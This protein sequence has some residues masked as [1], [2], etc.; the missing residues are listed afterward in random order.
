MTSHLDDE[1][2][3]DIQS[4]H[5]DYFDSNPF[6]NDPINTQQQHHAPLTTSSRHSIQ[7]SNNNN[8]S[9]NNSN[10][11]H[12]LHLQHNQPHQ[13][14]QQQQ[15]MDSP[16]MMSNRNNENEYDNDN[17]D[18][19]MRPNDDDDHHDSHKSSGLTHSRGKH[20]FT[21]L[22]KVKMSKFESLDFPIIDNQ[23]MRDFQ[24]KTTIFSHML[25]TFGKWAICFTIGV[26]VGCV[27]YLVK[28]SVEFV[29]EF[30][31]STS[32]RYT[33]EGKK[34][35]AFFVYYSINLLFGVLA[36]LIIIPVGQISSGSGI[37]EVKGYLNGI[38]IPQSMNA[39]TLIGKA[40]S[41]IFAYSSGLVLGPEGPMIH[42]G[43]MVG[44]AIGQVKS[45][46]FKW[47][48]KLFWRYHNDRDRRDF[49]STGAAAGVAAAFGAPIGGVLFGYEE[50]SSFWS[51]QL[52]WRTFFACLIATFT[53]NL[54]LQ[55]FQVQVH[56]YGVLT[57][58]FSQEYL[59]RY[60]ELLAFAALGVIGGLLGAFFVYLNVRLS[61]WR[62]EFFSKLPVYTRVLEVVLVVTLTSVTLFTAAGVTG[63]REQSL[64]HNTTIIPNQN[65]TFVRLFCEEDQYNDMAGLSFNTMD[66]ALRLLYSRAVNL[67]SIPTLVVFTFISFILATIT[68]GLMLA[69]GL[70]IPM[71]LLGGTFGRLVGQLGS[72]MFSHANPPI[73]PSIYA[74]VGSSAM[75]AGFSRMTIS[76]AIIVVELT[77][78]TQ[79]MLP[80][81]LSVMIAKWVGDIFNESIY[82]HLMELKCY[83]YLPS[84]PPKSMIKL[85]ITDVMKTEVVTLFEVDK[86]SRIMDVLQSNQHAGFPVIEKHNPKTVDSGDYSEDGIYCGMILRSQLIILLNYKIFTQEQQRLPNNFK[87][88]KHQRR[89]GKA[90]DY[91][92][93][94]ADGRMTYQVMT[95][96][97]ARHFPPINQMGIT[98][99]E[100]ENMYIDLRPY[101]NL[102]SVVS[103][104][105]FSFSEGYQLFRTMGLRHMPVVN[106][107]NEVVGI[108]TR[109]DL[110]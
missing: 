15:Q 93:I 27:A 81:I 6:M 47:Y 9:N 77:E 52:T 12:H 107:R 74:M 59:Y 8:N 89:W 49:I 23:I 87:R 55:G 101:M 50:A 2:S 63:C 105:T 106:K 90:T 75:M 62:S 41:L 29:N 7:Y 26:V 65:I 71:M 83:P 48:P 85:G 19:D 24:K 3:P 43:S 91:G 14:H 88:G 92:H 1:G 33:E 109:K 32:E 110:L 66:A 30:K 103:N 22:E 56:D 35:P 28:Q 104:E 54:I 44:G 46:T 80:V 39:K 51:K 82:E 42:I 86:V 31:F 72:I 38:R 21:E 40:V 79:Y 76:L 73:D 94:P 99:E 60:S 95:Q 18:E 70:F 69:S 96:A 53:T 17:I 5:N 37:P 34:I 36:S 58:G 57:F 98:K 84:Q 16:I 64:V 61:K 11:I 100:M 97:L 10:S 67:F 78:G 68:S 25:K 108:V 13:Q 20:T 102:S 4:E 45:K